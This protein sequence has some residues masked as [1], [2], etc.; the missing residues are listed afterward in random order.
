MKSLL[1]KFYVVNA[2]AALWAA[3]ICDLWANWAGRKLRELSENGAAR[4]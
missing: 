1:R 3:A 2:V 4:P